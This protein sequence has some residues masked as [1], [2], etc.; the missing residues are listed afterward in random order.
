ME[1]TVDARRAGATLL[2]GAMVL[3]GA[4]AGLATLAG[5]GVAYGAPINATEEAVEIGGASADAAQREVVGEFAYTQDAVSSTTEISSVFNKAAAVLCAKMPEYTADALS[6]NVKLV[7][8][9]AV[10]DVALD[11]VEGDEDAPVLRLGC[12]CSSN[13]AGGGAIMNADISG[14][15]LSVLSDVVWAVR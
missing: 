4:G 10:M 12:A 11:A 2:A 6:N 15:P 9:A 13:V 5:E 1:K 14:V 3:T 8:P 7:S